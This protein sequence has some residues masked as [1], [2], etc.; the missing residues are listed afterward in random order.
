[1]YQLAEAL[2]KTL[3]E[4]GAMPVSEFH[5]WLAHYKIKAENRDRR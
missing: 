4:I 3:G 1:M 5:G 2:H